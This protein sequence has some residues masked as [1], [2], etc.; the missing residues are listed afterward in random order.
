MRQNCRGV[1]VAG[2]LAALGACLLT[3][4]CHIVLNLPA[5]PG[6]PDPSPGTPAATAPDE[7]PQDVQQASYTIPVKASHPDNDAGDAGPGVIRADAADSESHVPPPTS[8]G[9]ELQ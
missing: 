2:I 7:H 1:G 9:A 8:P 6:D 5:S 3:A 4:G